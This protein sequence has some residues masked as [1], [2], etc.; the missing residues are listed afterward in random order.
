[1]ENKETNEKALI[2]FR[3]I[4]SLADA[5]YKSGMFTDVK[6]AA[7]ALV[8][9]Q[10][11]KELGLGAVYSMQ[12]LYM[13]Q[14]KLGMAAET[15]GALLKRSGKY[16]Y[17]VLEHTDQKCSIAF[18]E[19]GQEVYISTFTIEDAKRAGLIKP[20]SGWVKYPRAL[21]FSRA[22]SQGARIVGPDMTGGGYTLEELQSIEPIALPEGKVAE[23][24]N[25]IEG[26][27]LPEQR[28]DKVEPAEKVVETSPLQSLLSDCP[29]H[30][31]PWKVGKYGRFH[32]MPTGKACNFRNAI[33][34]VV[35]DIVTAQGMDATQFNELLKT[36]YG[37]RTWS[38][39]PEE[40]QVAIL[41]MLKERK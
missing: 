16:N 20:D 31:D 8:K 35:K 22:L 17:K 7:Q 13:V 11:G 5:F 33:K 28:E 34:P 37:G 25:V 23:S 38:K 27:V 29:E 9:I 12:K 4:E 30:G 39:I 18:Y 26:E 6:S 2:S 1:M 21:L 36:N 41:A 3:E 32:W 19:L 24:Q 10:A 40:E 14:G 15:M